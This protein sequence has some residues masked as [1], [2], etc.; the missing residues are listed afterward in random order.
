MNVTVTVNGEGRE[1]EE[2]TTLGALVDS[3]QGIA[4]ALNGVVVPATSWSATRLAGGDSVEVVTAHQG[5]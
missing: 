4:I 2:G 1:L 3:P 5:G